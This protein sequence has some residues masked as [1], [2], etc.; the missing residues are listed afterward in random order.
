MHPQ[1]SCNYEAKGY[2]FEVTTYFTEGDYLCSQAAA[3]YIEQY[4][5]SCD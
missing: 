3:S 5:K 2:H 1:R 4:P